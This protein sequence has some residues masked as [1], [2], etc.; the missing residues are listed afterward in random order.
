MLRDEEEGGCENGGGRGDV[1]RVV[2]VAAGADDIALH[3]TEKASD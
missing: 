2:A 3:E 1:E